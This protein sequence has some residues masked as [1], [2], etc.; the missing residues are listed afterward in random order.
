MWAV[1]TAVTFALW[2]RGIGVVKS[3]NSSYVHTQA[4]REGGGE[5]PSTLLALSM[6]SVVFPWRGTGRRQPSPTPTTVSLHVVARACAAVTG[7][8]RG[9]VRAQAFSPVLQ[10]AIRMLARLF[11]LVV[12]PT[13]PLRPAPRFASIH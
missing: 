2:A 5:T 11:C 9:F 8:V 13:P 10:K 6:S 4:P 12:E 7:V 3:H 1:N